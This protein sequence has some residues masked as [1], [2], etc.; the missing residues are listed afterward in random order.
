MRMLNFYFAA[1]WYHDIITQAISLFSFK[2]SYLHLTTKFHSYCVLIAIFN[3]SLDA[4]SKQKMKIKKQQR[5]QIL[6]LLSQ[7]NKRF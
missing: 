2:K 4:A 5:F 6:I 3:G 7:N 1:K